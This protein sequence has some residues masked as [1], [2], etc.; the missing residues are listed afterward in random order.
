MRN[1]GGIGVGPGAGGGNLKLD[2][3]EATINAIAGRP[4]LT[5]DQL[6][7]QEIDLVNM[8]EITKA[9]AEISMNYPE[10]AKHDPAKW[11]QYTE[12]MILATM[13][14]QAAVKKCD[15]REVKRTINKLS[16]CC[17]NCH[18]LFRE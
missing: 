16:A 13:D 11:K 5:E 3:I 6:K 15:P 12:E 7:A 18:T 4:K 14:A 17:G 2:G 10:E 9:I 8:L 1:K